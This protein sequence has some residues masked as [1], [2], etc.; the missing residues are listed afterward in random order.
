MA[1]DK[2][3][4]F[5][6]TTRANLDNQKSLGN[7]IQGEPYL[8]TDENRFAIG[9]ANNNYEDFA[10]KSELDSKKNDY[11]SANSRILG[12]KSTGSGAIE[13]LTLNEILDFIGSAQEGDI[14]YRASTGW[15]RL[16]KGTDGQVLTLANGL[17]VWSNTGGYKSLKYLTSDFTTSST[18][19]VEITNLT[20]QLPANKLFYF[21]VWLFP[22]NSNQSTIYFSFNINSILFAVARRK[23]ASAEVAEISYNYLNYIIS[24]INSSPNYL[25]LEGYVFTNANTN[26]IVKTYCTDSSSPAIIRMGSVVYIAEI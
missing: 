23:I 21:S 17:P 8:I 18:S 6:R 5:L 24:H 15:Q 22:D 16:P 20:H 14:L 1:R 19:P 3:L 2:I 9:I 25:V 10:K 7:L 11:V 26:A 4:K 12:R 13:E